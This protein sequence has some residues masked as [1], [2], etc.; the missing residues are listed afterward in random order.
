LIKVPGIG[1]DTANRILE[2]RALGARFK[3]VKELKNVGVIM[4]R[5]GP[6]VDIG[7]RQTRLTEINSLIS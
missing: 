4:K 5:A 2:S 7:S 3:N 1:P 6:F